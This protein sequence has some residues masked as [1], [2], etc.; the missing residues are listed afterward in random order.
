MNPHHFS[1]MFFLGCT[2]RECKPNEILIEEY[3]NMFESRIFLLE[4]PKNYQRGKSLTQRRLHS[5]TTWKDMLENALRDTASW[6]TKKW[7]SFTKSQVLAWMII[8]SNKK[9]LNQ[10]ENCQKCAHKLSLKCLYLARIG[11]PNNILWLVIN[12]ATAV[13]KWTQACD[14]RLARWIS[15]IHHTMTSDNIVMFV[16]PL[17]IDDWVYS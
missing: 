10:W 12:L 16:T 13:T 6:Q 11:G 7:S 8:N 9:N 5:P 4:Q 1:T 2:Q 15:Y 14:R 17:S 3:R